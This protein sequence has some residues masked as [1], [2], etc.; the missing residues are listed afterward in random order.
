MRYLLLLLFIVSCENSIVSP[1]E[2]LFRQEKVIQETRV[3]ITNAGC[4]PCFQIS[5]NKHM[6]RPDYIEKVPG[7]SVGYRVSHYTYTFRIDRP[8]DAREAIDSIWEEVEKYL[9]SR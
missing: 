8:F 7:C 4:Y 1:R 9:T 5:M 2:T 3:I 6:G